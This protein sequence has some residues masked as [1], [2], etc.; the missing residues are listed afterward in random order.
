[1]GLAALY[2][3]PLEHA[4][5]NLLPVALGPLVLG[6][7]LVTAWTWSECALVSSS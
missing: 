2:S 6:S 3:H 1:M 7:H 5:S 4:V